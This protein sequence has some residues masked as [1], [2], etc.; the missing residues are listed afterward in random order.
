[1]YLDQFNQ[2]HDLTM[3]AANIYQFL[4]SMH[5]PEW[6]RTVAIGST[7]LLVLGLLAWGLRRRIAITPSVVMLIFTWCAIL[8]PYFLP[9]MHERYYYPADV[10]AVLVSFQL[11]RRLWALPILV[12]LGPALTYMGSMFPQY[13]VRS[14]G[15]RF[16]SDPPEWALLTGGGA[17][18]VALAVAT[19]AMLRAFGES[20]D[21]VA[22]EPQHTPHMP[23]APVPG[24]VA[25]E[26]MY[27]PGRPTSYG[28]NVIRGP[29][30]SWRMSFAPVTMSPTGSNRASPEPR[31]PNTC[32]AQ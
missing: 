32:C 18:T 1:M 9:S 20:R 8:I 14:P 2:Y 19:W 4:G 11:P 7:G 12:Q 6:L 22:A 10:L 3:N 17:M 5:T 27:I 30:T 25:A 31:R 24:G 15:A 23:W 16:A 29:K 21:E 13:A 28:D 26:Q